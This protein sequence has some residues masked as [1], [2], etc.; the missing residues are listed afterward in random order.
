MIILGQFVSDF[1]IKTFEALLMSIHSVCFLWK[2]GENHPSP[3]SPT[4]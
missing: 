2:T 1:S 3:L 4:V